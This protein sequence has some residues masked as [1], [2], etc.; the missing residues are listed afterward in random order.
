MKKRLLARATAHPAVTDV[1]FHEE[2]MRRIVRLAVGADAPFIETP[3]PDSG[4]GIAA[5]K[6]HL[7]G[8]QAGRIA[9]RAT[10]KSITPFHFS[11][12]YEGLEDRLLA[13]VQAAHQEAPGG[14]P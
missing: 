14:V 5:T 4:A 7:T 12:R 13:E 3:F 10:A 9:V 11:P 6:N 1:S 8:A 2:N